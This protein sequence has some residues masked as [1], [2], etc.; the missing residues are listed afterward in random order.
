MN[1]AQVPGYKIV[2]GKIKEIS[3]AINIERVPYDSSRMA[4]KF[5]LIRDDRKC[6]VVFSRDFLEDLN[7]FTG[8]KKS[9]YWKKMESALIS[10]LLV[11]IE[12]HGLTPFTKEKLKELIFEHVKK[13]LQS[14]QHINKFNLLGRPYQEGS[15]ENFIGVKFT[16]AERATAGSAFDELK[17]QGIL[18][19]T[20]KDLIH[21]EDWVKIS[22]VGIEKEEGKVTREN[23]KPKA[24]IS[25]SSKDKLI[26]TKVK[27]MLG[28][29][30]I[31][32]FLAH[33]DIN[34]S[35]EWKQRIR[36]ELSISDIFIPLLSKNFKDS[37]WAPQETGIAYFRDI[38]IIPLRLDKT[39]PFGFINHLQ[40]K[41][42]S[43]DDIPLNYLIKPIV[44]KFPRYMA[45]TVIG[46]LD[47]A[48][49]FRYAESVMELLVPYFDTFEQK[50]IDRFAEA[51]IKNGQIWNAAL[52]RDNYLPQ[53][54]EIN[55]SKINPKHLEMLSYQIEKGELYP[56]TK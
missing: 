49:S 55:K 53:F 28:D 12:K 21:P 48:G 27:D 52:C 18:I 6:G 22:D 4:Y 3:D 56:K 13:A 34:V 50:D 9:E 43:E 54:I 31:E 23:K 41:P 29:F 16:E 26:G 5:H 17:S 39:I 14:T 33:N 38:L 45:A 8:S 36:E 30:G 46:R 42:I 47:S 37:D 20:Y 35:E 40:G 25:Y 10:A 51:S 19:P 44:D 7:D 32:G 15:L 24:F 1:E 2:E 11:P